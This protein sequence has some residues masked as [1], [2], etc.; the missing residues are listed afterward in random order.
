MAPSKFQTQFQIKVS[1]NVRTFFLATMSI[2]KAIRQKSPS[3]LHKEVKK[4]N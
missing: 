1:Q 4:E 2:V 3:G